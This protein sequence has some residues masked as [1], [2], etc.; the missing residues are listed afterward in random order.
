MIQVITFDL[1]NTLFIN[2][3]YSDERISYFIEFLDGRKNIPSIIK[4]KE[5]FNYAFHLPEREFESINFRHIYTKDRISKML[6]FLKIDL[7]KPDKHKIKQEFE[8]I[9][10][11]DP[12]SLKKGVKKTLQ[13]LA[14]IYKVGLISNTGITPGYVIKKVLKKYQILQYF[15]LTLFSD[16]TGFY[17]PSPMMFEMALEKLKC[18]PHNAIHIG[19]IL[20]TDIKG[21]KESRMLAIWFND[22]FSSQSSDVQPDFEIHQI[23]EIIE[24]INMLN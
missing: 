16:E 2:K 24:I 14:P 3:F 10:L 17:K 11:K 23:S 15:Q 7:T 19:D 1:W 5:A 22:S 4:V 6:E 8:E 13:K 20:E 18:K 12:P 9:M 21:A